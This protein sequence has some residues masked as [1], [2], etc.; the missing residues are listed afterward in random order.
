MTELWG[1]FFDL[2]G[3]AKEAYANSRRCSRDMEAGSGCRRM[4]FL[5][6]ETTSS[7][8]SSLT[9]LAAMTSGLK[10]HPI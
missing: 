7:S 2:P 1:E 8:N 5:I 6:G 3:A 4:L 10:S 9:V